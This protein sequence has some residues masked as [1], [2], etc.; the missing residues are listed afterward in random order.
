M[1]APS[2]SPGLYVHVPLCAAVCPYCDFAVVKGTERKR[3]RFLAAFGQELRRVDEPWQPFDTLYFGGGTPSYLAAEELTGL[4]DAIRE[5]LPL[6]A[7]P[8]I[9]LEVNPED[10]TP[11]ATR[12]WRALGVGTVSLGVQSFA[13][14]ELAFLGRHHGPEVAR[15]AVELCCEAGFAT[16]SVDLIYGLPGQALPALQRNL[17]TAVA[18]A[19]DHLSCYQLTVHEATPFGKRRQRGELA[20]LAEPAQA[21]HF[22][23]VHSFLADHGYPAYEVSNFTRGPEH[24]SLHNRKYWDHT[25]YLGLGPSAHSFDGQARWWNERKPGPYQLRLGAGERPIAGRE[26]LTAEEL[27]LEALMLGLRTTDGLALGRFQARYGYDLE[28]VNEPR[29][30]ALA[31]AGRLERRTVGGEVWWAP[32]RRGLAVADGIAASLRLAPG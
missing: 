4:V 3:E 25:P 2:A 30:A 10:V 5:R 23:L 20:E 11:E 21:D 19:P 29:L 1:S 15:R 28:A 22:E 24:Q 31:A 27:A 8:R 26:E 16:V 13:A 7:A 17:E 18:L 12:A 9:Y 6:R 32:T 14:D